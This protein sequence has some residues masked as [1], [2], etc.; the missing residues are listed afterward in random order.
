MQRWGNKFNNYLL[1]DVRL[2]FRFSSHF[3]RSNITSN[4]FIV[5]VLGSTILERRD[6]DIFF[7]VEKVKARSF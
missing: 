6:L 2:E 3:L 7:N 5:K 1:R 4:I